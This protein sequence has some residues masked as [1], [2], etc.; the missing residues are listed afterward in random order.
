ME[1]KRLGLL[2]ELLP[3]APL[4]GV[5][6]NPRSAVF[7]TELNDVEG[8]ARAVDQRI[9]VM[10]ASNEQEIDAAFTTMQQLHA[11][12]VSVG[13][14][15]LFIARQ[16][17][18]VALARRYSIPAFYARKEFVEAGGLA[19]YGISSDEAEQWAGLT[20]G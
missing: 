13:A 8:G 2:R 14:D 18:I 5:L 3:R 4:I 7:E 11:A 17:Q 6:L 16:E 19:S 20:R 9:Q 1:A 15:A 12:A 10:K